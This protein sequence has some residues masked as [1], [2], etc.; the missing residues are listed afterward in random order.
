MIN[1][2]KNITIRRFWLL[3]LIWN[4]RDSYLYQTG[5]IKSFK[6]KQPVDNS[7][8]EIPWLS[9][10]CVHFLDARINNSM[11]VFEYGLGNS[12][13]WF[14]KRVKE[15]I[16]VDHDEAWYN[17]V[18]KKLVSDNV[19]L[20]YSDIELD[21]INKSSAFGQKFHIIIIDGRKRVE[22]CMVGINNLTPD[23]VVIFDDSQR[24]EYYPALKH[25]V[26]KG[27]KRIDFWGMNAGSIDF[28]CTSIFYKEN[29][30][31]AI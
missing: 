27:F 6:K 30:C 25:M 19:K 15:V 24:E 18:K 31:L 2:L 9:L 20:L 17:F 7:G 29:N 11:K 16:S 12:T 28:K 5:W 3:K 10:P 4:K 8:N 14:S 13:F 21:Y 26:G 1:W 23:G 22:S